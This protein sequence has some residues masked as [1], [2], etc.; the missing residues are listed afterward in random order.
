M[1]PRRAGGKVEPRPLQR[2]QESHHLL[3]EREVIG[4]V[5]GNDRRGETLVKRFK[6]NRTERVVWNLTSWKQGTLSR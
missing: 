3:D 5:T 4:E 6:N 2:V 1:G